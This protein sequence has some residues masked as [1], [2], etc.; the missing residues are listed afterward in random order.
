MPR[1][2]QPISA[3][4][5][6]PA[7]AA[8]PSALPQTRFDNRSVAAVFYEV[9]EF[10]V[11]GAVAWHCHSDAC[12]PSRFRILMKRQFT[13]SFPTSGA[14]FLISGIQRGE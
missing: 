9:Q 7:E 11:G 6:A 3:T 4:E 10:G 1:K 14:A 5:P 8:P 12:L 13:P 2:M